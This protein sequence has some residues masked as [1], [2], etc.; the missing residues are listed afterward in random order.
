MQATIKSAIQFGSA[1]G[2]LVELKTSAL[3]TC[4]VNLNL[5]SGWF[6]VCFGP[7]YQI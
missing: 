2:R 7:G 3:V 5:N 4:H 1:V 6:L